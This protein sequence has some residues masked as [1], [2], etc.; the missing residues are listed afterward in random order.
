MKFARV[1]TRENRCS[2]VVV[3]ESKYIAKQRAR[4]ASVLVVRRWKC[5]QSPKRCP[6]HERVF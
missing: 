5:E 2:L 3:V 4:P 1:S 6:G